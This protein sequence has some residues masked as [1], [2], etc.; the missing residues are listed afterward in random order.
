MEIRI[1]KNIKTAHA[2][3]RFLASKINSLGINPL[4][5]EEMDSKRFKVTIEPINNACTCKGHE[6]SGGCGGCY[7][8]GL[9]GKVCTCRY[10]DME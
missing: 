6:H 3:R 10:N 5:K 7:F 9:S 8:G 2:R 4:S 1:P